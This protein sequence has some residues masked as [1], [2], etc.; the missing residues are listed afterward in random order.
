MDRLA[1]VTEFVRSVEYATDAESAGTLEYSRYLV[2]TVVEN[3]GDCEDLSTLLA[4][5]LASPPFEFDPA[6]MFF[7][8][9]VGVGVNPERLEVDSEQR[10][11]TSS[12][13]YYYVDASTDIPLGN[14]PERYVEPGIVAVYDGEWRYVNVG[15]LGE[16]AALVLR[17]GEMTNPLNYV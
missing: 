11:S 17:R 14:V 16:H 13:D 1:A 7:S 5:V 10:M 3:T 9:H 4:G 8:G 6:L 12:R 15:A 2:E